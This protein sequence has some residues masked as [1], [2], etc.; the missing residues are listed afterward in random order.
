MKVISEYILI[1][2]MG[3]SNAPDWINSSDRILEVLTMFIE[4]IIPKKDFY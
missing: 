3:K 4:E 1:Y 2:G